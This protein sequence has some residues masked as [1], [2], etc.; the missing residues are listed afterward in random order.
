MV[1]IIP[2]HKQHATQIVNRQTGVGS[3]K[4]QYSS[5][6]LQPYLDCLKKDTTSHIF[7]YILLVEK[8]Y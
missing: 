3:G 7:N 5:H 8:D 4:V 2:C 6:Y 1:L